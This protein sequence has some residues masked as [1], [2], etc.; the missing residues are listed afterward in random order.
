LVQS[1]NWQKYKYAVTALII[2]IIFCGFLFSYIA[3]VISASAPATKALNSITITNY[4]PPEQNSSNPALI[5]FSTGKY[6]INNG[7]GYLNISNTGNEN[8]ALALTMFA[9]VTAYNQ[10]QLNYN[11]G[12]VGIANLVVEAH[13][14]KIIIATLKDTN[15]IMNWTEKP[16]GYWG[17]S[18]SIQTSISTNYLFWHPA[19]SYKTFNFNGSAIIF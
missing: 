10:Q 12:S 16:S 13:S 8:Q 17:Y 14:S 1:G 18:W 9:T 19:V 2:I 6:T 4:I 7:V 5:S 3:V 11:L 15:P